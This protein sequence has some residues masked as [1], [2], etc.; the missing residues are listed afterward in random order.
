MTSS[1]KLEEPKEGARLAL[2]TVAVALIFALPLGVA[3]AIYL[4]QFAPKNRF[5]DLIEVNINN[6]AAVPSITPPPARPEPRGPALLR[7]VSSP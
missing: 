7:G 2:L 1:L 3:A 6:L 4:E 5:T